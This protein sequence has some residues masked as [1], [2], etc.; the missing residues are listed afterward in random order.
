MIAIDDDPD[1]IAAD[2]AQRGDAR[3]A[4]AHRRAARRRRRSHD[5]PDP[6]ATF[7][8]GGGDALPAIL[9]ARRPAHP[10]RAGRD[11]SR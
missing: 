10:P 4:A 7:V 9:D 2:R 3:R 8:G 1:A 11:R 5:L 6:D